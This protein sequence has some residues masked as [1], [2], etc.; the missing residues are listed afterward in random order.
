ML[1]A[2]EEAA[3]DFLL[4]LMNDDRLVDDDE[5]VAAHFLRF[6]MEFD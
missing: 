5:T 1:R 3:R 2:D 4:G 6:L